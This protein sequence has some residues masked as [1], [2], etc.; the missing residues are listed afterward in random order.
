MTGAELAT[1]RAVLE[2]VK[3]D[4]GVLQQHQIMMPIGLALLESEEEI[5]ILDLTTDSSKKKKKKGEK[6][7]KYKRKDPDG[8]EEMR[9]KKKA[10]KKAEKKEMKKKVSQ[11]EECLI[12]IIK[13]FSIPAGLP[14][15]L[16]DEVYILINCGDE[17]HWVLAAVIL[18]VRCIRVNA[19]MLQRR[20]FGTSSK[21]QKLAKIFSTYLDMSEFLDQKVRSDWSKI[22]AYR[23]KM[24]NPFDVLYVEGISQ[25]TIGI[26]DYGPFVAA[27]AKYLSDGL[28]VPN[29]GLDTK[30]F[31]KRYAAFLWKYGEAKAQKSYASDIKDPQR[32]KPNSVALNEEQLVHIDYILYLESV[33]VI[34]YLSLFNLL[35][36][37]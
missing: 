14:W 18:K 35:I 4:V 31:H 27:Y 1:F 6:K 3:A 23:D 24:G 13:G 22:E 25:Q 28:Q 21:I 30:L 15:H 16:V 11:N 2:K 20:C 36:C 8:E 12:N 37:L 5:P 32:P 34:T 9:V 7:G 26:L 10:K 19:S 17:F 33:N 29:N